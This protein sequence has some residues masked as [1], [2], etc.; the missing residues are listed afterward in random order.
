MPPGHSPG[1]T[2]DNSPRLSQENLSV[3]YIT[4][5]CRKMQHG[6][7]TTMWYMSMHLIR[8]PQDVQLWSNVCLHHERNQTLLDKL[9][10]VLT[11]LFPKM[12]DMVVLTCKP[13]TQERGKDDG[14]CR[15]ILDCSDRP[16]LKINSHILKS[17]SDL[18][19]ENAGLSVV[20]AHAYNL[21][22]EVVNHETTSWRP[23]W[24]TYKTASRRKT[25]TIKL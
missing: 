6:N 18:L 3:E 17:I 8:H 19:Y 1:C 16:W 14:K 5:S 25:K 22:T 10:Q 24:A 11:L 2:Q 15:G 12:P 13:G 20:A 4:C 9:I 7:V 23:T 21:K